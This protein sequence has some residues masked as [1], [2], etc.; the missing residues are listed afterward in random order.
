MSS[1]TGGSARAPV[2]GHAPAASESGHASGRK[3]KGGE[4][5]KQGNQNRKNKRRLQGYCLRRKRQKKGKFINRKRVQG[6]KTERKVVQTSCMKIPVLQE[7]QRRPFNT[8]CVFPFLI[9][10]EHIN[11][12]II[13]KPSRSEVSNLQ[14]LGRNPDC[15]PKSSGSHSVWL[16]RQ[17]SQGTDTPQAWAGSSAMLCPACNQLDRRL[18]LSSQAPLLI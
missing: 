17:N 15:H 9:T 12:H 8:N 4:G 11:I 1:Q 5:R 13:T 18:H 3:E 7:N 2:F 10:H 6:L 16:G 14:P